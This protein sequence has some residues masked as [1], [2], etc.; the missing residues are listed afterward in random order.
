MNKQN[1]RKFRGIFVIENSVP[2]YH[3][4]YRIA[5]GGTKNN[6]IDL[7]K[8]YGSE[9]EDHIERDDVFSSPGYI[10]SS[11][12]IESNNTI[13]IHFNY[14]DKLEGDMV[15]IIAHEAVHSS[16][17]VQSVRGQLFSPDCQEAQACIIDY[18]T[19]EIYDF[20]KYKEKYIISQFNKMSKK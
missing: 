20:L 1:I 4:A 12:L 16:W 18:F 2:I 10:A 17:H 9:G 8:F 13:F 7:V 14:F 6:I 19:K 3:I 5:I 11:S 15:S